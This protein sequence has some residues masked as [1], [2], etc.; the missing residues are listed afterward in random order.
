MPRTFFALCRTGDADA[1]KRIPLQAAVQTELEGL[2]DE[3]EAAFLNGRDED[4]V[5]DGGWKPDRNQLL[6]I[7]DADLVSPFATTLV[8]GPAAYENLDIANYGDAG[9]KAIFTHSDEDEDRILI[10]KFRT[11]QFLQKSG[12][13]LVFSNNQF[14]KLSEQG[15][16]LDARL[17]AV[18]ENSVVKFQSF[19]SLRT[20]LTVQYHFEQATYEEVNTFSQHG[21]FHIEN[22]ALFDN[23]MDERSRK[24]I[25]G[26]SA[27]GVLAN[28]NVTTI[29]EKAASVGLKIA[30]QDGRLVLPG[31]KRRLKT[32]LSFLEESVFKGV[33]SEE[34]F[35]TNSKRAVQ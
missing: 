13:T 22:Q 33:F 3:Q 9:I 17:T 19:H 14:G 8:D 32:I 25:R 16:A 6:T 7:D 20:I 30:E 21:H 18:I 24:L 34:V 12:I 15:F 28:Y 31:E 26:I 23:A 35:E 4:V 2:F 10:Q 11:S 1:V 27:S 5:F 29:R